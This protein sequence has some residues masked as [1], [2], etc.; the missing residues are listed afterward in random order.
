MN[1]SD[2]YSLEGSGPWISADTEELQVSMLWRLQRGCVADQKDRRLG[3]LETRY[4]TP[5]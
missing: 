5:I 1:A 4:H 2:I 3:L